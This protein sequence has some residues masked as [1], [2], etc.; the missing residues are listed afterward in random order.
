MTILADAATPRAEV[1]YQVC[2]LWLFVDASKLAESRKTGG[3][4]LSIHEKIVRAQRLVRLLEDDEPLLAVRVAHLTPEGQQAAKDF[5]DM[6]TSTA[7]AELARLVEEKSI[8]EMS[9][10][11]PQAA[12]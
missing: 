4:M 7:R 10:A 9:E 11:A 12:D 2:D 3:V 8:W 5:A 6:L 1:R